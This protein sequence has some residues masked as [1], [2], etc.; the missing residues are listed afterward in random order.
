MI[1]TQT[2]HAEATTTLSNLGN[3]P[4][5]DADIVAVEYV[6]QGFVVPAGQ[7]YV[8]NSVTFTLSSVTGD[9]Q[10][11]IWDD[12]GGVPGSRVAI[13][14]RQFI[15]LFVRIPVTFTPPTPILLSAGTPY[16]FVL[17]GAWTSAWATDVAP[18][19]IF[20]DAGSFHF[21]AGAWQPL[22][23]SFPT[24]P[25]L[26]VNVDAD[27]FTSQTVTPPT[28]GTC[29]PDNRLNSVCF[30]PWQTAAIYCE[31]GDI[32]VYGIGENSEGHLLFVTSA[33]EIDAIG[34]PDENTMIESSHDS[35]VR[36]YRLPS[37]EFQLN[38]PIVDDVRGYLPNGYVFKWDGGYP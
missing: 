15:T 13:V 8:L 4:I 20:T 33:D 3:T 12:N 10:V 22:G 27:P 28:V 18:T 21:T 36:L 11:E 19:G 26:L 6:G 30:E 38:S 2:E 9:I 5:I 16:H 25:H 24:A 37:G 31:R 23:T 35:R 17:Q 34:I 1:S 7:D 14:Q 29:E 32:H